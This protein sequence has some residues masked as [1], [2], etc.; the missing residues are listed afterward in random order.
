MAEVLKAKDEKLVGVIEGIV[1]LDIEVQE[2]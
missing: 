1:F 2:S